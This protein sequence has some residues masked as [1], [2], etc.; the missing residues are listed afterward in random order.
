MF[1]PKTCREHA[2]KCTQTA[3]TFPPGEQRQK[4][5]DMAEDWTRLAASIED[6]EASLSQ[7]PPNA[8]EPYR[9]GHELRRPVLVNPALPG[10]KSGFFSSPSNVQL[11]VVSLQRTSLPAIRVRCSASGLLDGVCLAS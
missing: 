10:G 8:N 2:S 6:L 5:L 4:F 1:N 3:E 7:P 9:F 11:T